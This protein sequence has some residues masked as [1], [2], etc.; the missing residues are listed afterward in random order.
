MSSGYS[1]ASHALI[2]LIL[3]SDHCHF[4]TGGRDKWRAPYCGTGFPYITTYSVS[5]GT[6]PA[7][8]HRTKGKLRSQRGK[9]PKPWH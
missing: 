2:G 4:S 1:D 6:S 9:L 5:I 8:R 3:W 7:H